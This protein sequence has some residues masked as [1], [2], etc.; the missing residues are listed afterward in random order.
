MV[1]VAVDPVR[2]ESQPLT[3]KI[4]SP[5]GGGYARA[6]RITVA[7][8]LCHR[9]TANTLNSIAFQHISS[10]TAYIGRLIDTALGGLAGVGDVAGRADQH[11]DHLGDKAV[12]RAVE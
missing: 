1:T 7:F 11:P 4:A 3:R 6:R 8:Q 10:G 2:I 9:T 12:A 5:A